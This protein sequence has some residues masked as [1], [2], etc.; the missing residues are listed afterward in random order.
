PF[1]GSITLDPPQPLE[2][3]LEGNGVAVSAE[4]LER[5]NVRV[6]DTI[7][8]AGRS[9]RI[10]AAI[11]GEPDRFASEVGVGLR[12]M[13]S[14]A[15]FEREGFEEPP[16]PVKHRVLLRLDAGSNLNSARR[17]LEQLFPAGNLRDYRNAHRQEGEIIETVIAFLSLTA[18]LAMA[19]GAL[20]A[21]VALREH[22]EQSLSTLAI[23]RMLGA[24]TALL[25]AVFFAEAGAMLAAAVAIGIP[26]GYLLRI[27]I[28]S[29]AGRYL[30]LASPAGWDWLGSIESAAAA[31][32]I[33]APVMVQPAIWIRRIRP[34][35]V[36]RRAMWKGSAAER[37]P[38]IP[39]IARSG[40]NW[41][42][43]AISCV[44]FALLGEWILNSWRST[45]TLAL[46][47]GG[48][49]VV[50]L[51]LAAGAV[52]AVHWGIGRVPLG[53]RARAPR[54]HFGLASLSG[55]GRR[56][57][58][59]I[60]ALAVPVTLMIA[61]FESRGAVVE[62][63]INVLPS[64]RMNLYVAGF[65][66]SEYTRLVALLQGVSGAD[67][68]V[69]T[70]ARVR[71]SRVDSTGDDLP[72]SI[73]S[74]DPSLMVKSSPIKMN[75]TCESGYTL[76][77]WDGVDEACIETPLT[78]K[79][80]SSEM[81]SSAGGVRAR[82]LQ[83]ASGVNA[84]R[85]DE[86]NYYYTNLN[87]RAN[88]VDVF[89]WASRFQTMTVDYYLERRAN[90]ELQGSGSFLAACG[91]SQSMQGA[92]SALILAPEPALALNA[93]VGSH[94]RAYTRSNSFDVQVTAVRELPES[95]RIWAP[96]EM[97][98]GKVDPDLLIHEAGAR[99]PEDR[100]LA[101]ARAIRESYP[102]VAVVTKQEVEQTIAS[103]TNNALALTRLVGWYAIG[104]GFGVLLAMVAATRAAR[105]T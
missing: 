85:S 60:A 46:A 53:W 74:G 94:F 64:D 97:D 26:C 39:R 98:C 4:V 86:W 70:Q 71:L 103:L 69:T 76:H 13:V 24:R 18:F 52:R 19:L 75:G 34:A 12:C 15:A 57:A 63:F 21:G 84:L 32:A 89:P 73:P 29:I 3:A 54:I 78:A 95:E 56:A 27:S 81:R 16:N 80:S 72:P 99:V 14:R 36:L 101:A 96:I 43:L 2:R 66:G 90:V 47:I 42:V 82:M 8:L 11:Q 65:K 62:T 67:V 93:R 37:A 68:E 44:A 59:L 17:M 45:W 51:A 7:A 5:F 41:A 88:P 83:A 20:A 100:V 91:S 33:A 31:L 40:T 49:G 55:P 22:A 50:T 87:P 77:S 92:S 6:G 9:F 10:S 58:T 1:Y 104:C 23:L 105:R 35:V 28:L 48:T 102:A 79:L 61:M 25:D 30:I 38:S